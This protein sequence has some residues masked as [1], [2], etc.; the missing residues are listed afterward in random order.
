MTMYC[1]IWQTLKLEGVQKHIANDGSPSLPVVTFNV[2]D[3]D[4]SVITGITHAAGG[5]GK[6]SVRTS[7]EGSV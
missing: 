1:S 4:P 5:A 2:Y 7:L 6:G 3:L